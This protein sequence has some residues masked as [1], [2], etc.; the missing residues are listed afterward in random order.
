MEL[1]HKAVYEL[2]EMFE[3]DTCCGMGGSYS[4]KLPEISTPIL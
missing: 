3:G 4:L 2:T 1:L